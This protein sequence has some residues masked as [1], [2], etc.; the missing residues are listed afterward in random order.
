MIR[1]ESCLL[2]ETVRPMGDHYPFH[3][4]SSIR[5]SGHNADSIPP[6]LSGDVLRLS[7]GDDVGG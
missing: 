2:T 5:R 6:E 1:E 3:F 7:I 4:V